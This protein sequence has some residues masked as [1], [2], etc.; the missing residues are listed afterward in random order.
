MYLQGEVKESDRSRFV[1][2]F[3]LS[4]SLTAL[5]L[6]PECCHSS[7][8]LNLNHSL[9]IKTRKSYKDILVPCNINNH[10]RSNFDAKLG[11]CILGRA[12]LELTLLLVTTVNPTVL[13]VEF[14]AVPS[15]VAANMLSYL[16]QYLSYLLRDLQVLKTSVVN[17]FQIVEI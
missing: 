1:Y 3:Q 7:E 6:P 4:I 17:L 12:S 16:L 9:K 11:E 10:H 14:S 5:P 15:V 2:N 8:V 13:C